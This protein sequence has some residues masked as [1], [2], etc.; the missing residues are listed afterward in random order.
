MS[1][2]EGLFGHVEVLPYGIGTSVPE[3]D[4][5]SEREVERVVREWEG[6]VEDGE[7]IIRMHAAVDLV[8]D[9]SEDGDVKMIARKYLI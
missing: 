7:G 1:L 3:A 2:P 6:D 8:V 5:F 9:T 4:S